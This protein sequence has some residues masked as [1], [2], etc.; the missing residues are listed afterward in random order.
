MALPD[1][2]KFVPGTALVFSNSGEYSPADAG[3]PTGTNA[4]IDLGELANGVCKQ[5]VKL[6][7]GSANLDVQWEMRAY[8]EYHSAPTA[9]G[10]INFYLGFS[11]DATAG[12]D[13]PANL[14]GTDSAFEGYGADAASGIE[15][16]EQLDYIGSLVVTADADLQVSP[17]W[18]FV[19]KSRWCCLVV[20]NQSSVNLANTD[21]IETG[22]A[23]TPREVQA[24][25]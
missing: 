3:Q 17:K 21:A 2:I 14:A 23:I 11:S 19:P 5:S 25:D 16:L 22:I 4:D 1:R 7:L 6:D 13:N 12:E 15:A 24:Q 8:I 18:I 10:V 9:G 20:E